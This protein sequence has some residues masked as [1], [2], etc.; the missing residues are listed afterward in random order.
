[1][2]VHLHF[3]V[4]FIHTF[5]NTAKFVETFFGDPIAHK[6][7]IFFFELIHGSGITC[8]SPDKK[9]GVLKLDT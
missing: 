9:K 4:D 5:K 6:R 1:M 2:L 7:D 8:I 3:Q